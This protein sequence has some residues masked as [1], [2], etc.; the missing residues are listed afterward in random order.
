M[1]LLNECLL[2]RFQLLQRFSLCRR[3]VGI[4]LMNFVCHLDR[5]SIFMLRKHLP[6]K[7]NNFIRF[8]LFC[9]L[10]Q[11]QINTKTGF[12]FTWMFV[13]NRKWQNKIVGW[14]EVTEEQKQSENGSKSPVQS[15]NTASAR[16]PIE[17]SL[18]RSSRDNN[19][20]NKK[21]KTT[22]NRKRLQTAW[23]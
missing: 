9:R 6:L 19:S 18:S 23:V 11:Q 8:F 10:T 1:T 22:N 13:Q 14:I 3:F 21:T 12:R 16:F 17:K 4:L 7:L 15:I 20:A 5:N 2:R